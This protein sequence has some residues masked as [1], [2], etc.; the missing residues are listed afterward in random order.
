MALIANRD[1][2]EILLSL[3]DTDTV[4][5][6]FEPEYHQDKYRAPSI[7]AQHH[8]NGAFQIKESG[9]LAR[10][11]SR[12]RQPVYADDLE[13]NK[14]L[15]YVGMVTEDGKQLTSHDTQNIAALKSVAIR[16]GFVDMDSAR[17]VSGEFY[18]KYKDRSGVKYGDLLI[19]STGDGTIGRVAVYHYKYP[20]VVDGHITILRFSDPSIA[21]YVSAY[22]NTD[23]GQHQIY[24]YVNGSSGQVEIYPQDIGRLWIP[25]PTDQEKE[26]LMSILTSATQGFEEFRNKMIN[27]R[28]L[29]LGSL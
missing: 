15:R 21:W 1:F 28:N 12:G 3:D 19:N 9:I 25:R 7:R 29:V 27:S 14:T 17:C 6:V 8:P 13:E 4:M 18:K 2:K 26:L 20:A 11:I 23:D 5:H 22:L 16:S 24:R 10:A